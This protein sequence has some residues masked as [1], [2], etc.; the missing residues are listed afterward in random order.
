MVIKEEAKEIKEG[1]DVK[2]RECTLSEEMQK[3]LLRQLK[4]EL[5]NENTYLTFANYF[6]VRGLLLLAKYFTL[7]SLEERRHASWVRNYLNENDAEYIMPAID[8]YGK[9]IEDI[10]QPFK[11]TVD[12][13]IKTTQMIYEMVDA[14]VDCRDY[15]CYNFLMGHDP[16]RGMLVDEQVNFCLVA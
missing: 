2:R 4:H 10:M 15:G 7:R 1:L 3:L 8:Q 11:E 9:K 5:E 6:E 16:E 14:S 13:E 12:L